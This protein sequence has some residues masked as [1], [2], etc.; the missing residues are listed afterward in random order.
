MEMVLR[1][2]HMPLTK[3][4]EEGQEGSFTSC[5]GRCFHAAYFVFGN[6]MSPDVHVEA[7]ETP[8]SLTE[9]AVPESCALPSSL[10]YLGVVATNPE[11]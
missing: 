9:G 3:T 5:C 6:R 4:G 7:V 8:A 10:S 1:Y 2:L 11:E